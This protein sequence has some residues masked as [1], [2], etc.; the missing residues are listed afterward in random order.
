VIYTL[1]IDI[2]FIPP[3]HWLSVWKDTRKVMLEHLGYDVENII[4]DKSSSGKGIHVWIRINA[5][6]LSDA[7]L[8]MLNWLMGDDQTRVKINLMRIERGE[9]EWNKLFSSVL[10]TRPVDEKCIKCKIRK[11][12][13]ETLK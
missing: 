7:D 1:K 10:W 12:V 5:G 3:A 13:T 9:K 8:N 4:V 2:D 11:Y 6:V